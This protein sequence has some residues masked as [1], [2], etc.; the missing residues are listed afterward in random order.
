MEKEMTTHMETPTEAPVENQTEGMGLYDCD[1]DHDVDSDILFS[2]EVFGHN[3]GRVPHQ[4]VVKAT[5]DL[6]QYADVCRFFELRVE[7][8]AKTVAGSVQ[9]DYPFAQAVAITQEFTNTWQ[10]CP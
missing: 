7:D 2:Y 10:G 3:S 6:W 1:C 9:R 4:D 5:Q 8:A